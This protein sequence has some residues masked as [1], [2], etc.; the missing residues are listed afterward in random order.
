MPPESARCKRAGEKITPSRPST[1]T[2]TATASIPIGELAATVHA[3]VCPGA[4]INKSTGVSTSTTGST[5]VAD[6]SE[7]LSDIPST[8]DWVTSASSG[9]VAI[10]ISPGEHVT[11]RSAR[12]AL[13]SGGMGGVHAVSNS[14]TTARPITFLVLVISTPCYFRLVPKLTSVCDRNRDRTHLIVIY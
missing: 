11:Y 10:A 5:T 1:V 14:A 2:D 8:Q 4:V 3:G 12:S 6:M 7:Q 13:N 9:T